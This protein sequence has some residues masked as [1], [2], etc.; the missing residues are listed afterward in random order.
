[1]VSMAG[2]KIPADLSC[3]IRAL[4]AL[5]TIDDADAQLRLGVNLCCGWFMRQDTRQGEKLLARAASRHS[6]AAGQTAMGYLHLLG[7]SM[8]KNP[9][10]AVLHFRKAA[11]VGYGPAQARLAWCYASGCGD[12][13]C[14]PEAAMFY[15]LA[16]EQGCAFAQFQLG[17]W[18]EKGVGVPKSMEEA[19]RWYELAA[20]QGFAD[21][22]VNLGQCF[23][24]G[25]GMPKDESL[26]FKLYG[27]A[28]YAGSPLGIL[29]VGIC[30]EQGIGV[31]ALPQ[32]AVAYYGRAA[33]LGS[34][35]AMYRFSLCFE[36]G[37]GVLQDSTAAI[38]WLLVAASFDDPDALV[39]LAS[40]WEPRDGVETGDEGRRAKIMAWYQKAAESGSAR[41][42]CNLAPYYHAAGAGQDMIA[43]AVQLLRT[44]AEQGIAEAQWNLG[45]L[46]REGVGVEKDEAEA[47][48][49]MQRARVDPDF[50]PHVS[51]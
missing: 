40:R 32:E 29:N 17:L 11:H 14:L 19:A 35:E 9:T 48:R 37:I 24:H 51:E 38:L 3:D 13:V 33:E 23:Q 50:D 10:E 5:A 36:R 42:Q 47:E 18:A 21:A 8:P 31:D 39:D 12:A 4:E 25:A 1:M 46:Y 2:V 6:T 26:A 34:P 7:L 44:A 20:H 27:R 49:W 16:A 30:L 28:A 22:L 15:M 41:A 45:L 43:K